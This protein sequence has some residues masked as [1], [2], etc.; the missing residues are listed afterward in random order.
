MLLC[1]R[2]LQHGPLVTPM[3]LA[4]GHGSLKVYLGW[5]VPVRLRHAGGQLLSESC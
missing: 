5:T 4:K 2:T 1:L 3:R